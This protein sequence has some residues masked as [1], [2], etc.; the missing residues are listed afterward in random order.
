MHSMHLIKN[1]LI[2][3]QFLQRSID[4]PDTIRSGIGHREG[5]NLDIHDKFIQVGDILLQGG[6]GQFTR[7][8]GR[9]DGH[10]VIFAAVQGKG[11][12]FPV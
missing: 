7:F 4:N 12:F 9:V 1:Q 2:A 5:G 10:G 6:C 8:G 11:A 3:R